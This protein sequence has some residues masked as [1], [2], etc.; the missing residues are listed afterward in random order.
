M[1]SAPEKA[2]EYR[3]IAKHPQMNSAMKLVL[4]AI[5]S[6]ARKLLPKCPCCH[7]GRV[8]FAHEE[9][10]GRTWI[11]VYLCDRCGKYFV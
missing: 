10:H 9:V 11:N 7:E 6:L 8:G 2:K 1:E 3:V 4:V 5:A